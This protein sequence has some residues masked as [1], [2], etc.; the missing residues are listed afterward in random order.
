MTFLRSAASWISPWQ[1]RASRSRTDVD[2][3]GI[4]PLGAG[5]L[6][7]A[8]IVLTAA[9]AVHA[10]QRAIL[11]PP[12]ELRGDILG[13]ARIIDGDTIDIAG[14]RIR[15]A[16]IDAPE[17][18][19]TCTDAGNRVWRCGRAA[20]QVLVEHLAARPL[21][22][23]ASGLDRYRRV[24]AV[25]ALPDGSDVNAWMVRQGWAL[26]YYSAAYR[27]EE[28]DARAAKRGIW[29]SRFIPPWE[30][31]HRHLHWWAHSF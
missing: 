31:R 19:Q 17:S 23:Q 30:W 27:A 15:L 20:T 4:K 28:A 24:L 21:K 6:W 26:A 2:W 29:A 25:C 9:F 12:G 1:A 13:A 8:I 3:T 11:A 18:D 14:T 7:L 22:C 5:P 10:W 16:G